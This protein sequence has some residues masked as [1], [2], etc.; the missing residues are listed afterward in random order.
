[1]L[2]LAEEAFDEVAALVEGGV[3]GSLDADATLGRNVCF[4]AEAVH[5]IDDSLTV[6][7][8]VGDEGVRGREAG[9][10]FRNDR[11]VGSLAR[12]NQQPDRQAVLVDDGVDFGAQSSTR[13][14]DG[15]IRAPFLPPAACW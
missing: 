4:A 12:R 8:A 7:A 15:V 13:T 1:M 10:Q 11:L 14:A 3:D 6:V 5:E 2:E 9:E